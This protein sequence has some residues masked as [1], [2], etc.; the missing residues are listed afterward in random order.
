MKQIQNFR[1]LV[2]ITLPIIMIFTPVSQTLAHGDHTRYSRL[3]IDPLI[4]H[5]SILEDE[6]RLNF[7]FFNNQRSEKQIGD[8][9]GLSLELAYALSDIFGV[10]AFIP[11]FGSNASG[12][13]L[14]GLGDIE[15]QPVKVSFYR[16]MNLVMTGVLSF[17]LPTGD[18]SKGF[19]SR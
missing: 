9:V 3:I 6:Q 19:G 16:S 14:R 13:T 17:V 5:H 10:E 4:T 12:K 11:F 7:F 1:F 8:G 15:V 18:D 2:L